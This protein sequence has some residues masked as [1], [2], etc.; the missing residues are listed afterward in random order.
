MSM[1]E[2]SEE[3]PSQ[4][5]EP[6]TVATRRRTLAY[7]AALVLGVIG[8][9]AAVAGVGL[10]GYAD[11]DDIAEWIQSDDVNVEGLS[12]PEAIDL[13]VE[14]LV[15]GT[16]GLVLAG[17]VLL[18]FGIGIVAHC[19][20]TSFESTEP[21][22]YVDAAIG[23]ATTMVTSFIPFSS[24]LGG[25]VAGYLTGQSGWDGARAGAFAGLALSLPA[26]ILGGFAIWATIEADLGILGVAF[27]FATGFVILFLVVLHTVGGYAG[28]A[29]RTR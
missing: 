25:G 29:I 17:L 6:P 27:A 19:R 7:L 21:D 10:H 18:L 3:K 4:D 20:R 8:L 2:A 14:L 13:V 16:T 15:W 24:V 22:L 9:I 1:S 11:R 23:A 28:A 5:A 26:A 12:E